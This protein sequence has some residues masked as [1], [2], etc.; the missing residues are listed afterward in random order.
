[1][2]SPTPEQCAELARRWPDE[3]WNHHGGLRFRLD[4]QLWVT[5]EGRWFLDN[6]T[7]SPLVGLAALTAKVLQVAAEDNIQIRVYG[8]E[9][10]GE[11]QVPRKAGVYVDG[12]WGEPEE[13]AVAALLT[14]EGKEE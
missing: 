10:F 7:I 13:S 8:P 14:T 5:P 9:M 3:F 1:M 6:F 4:N 11:V 2:D 12:S